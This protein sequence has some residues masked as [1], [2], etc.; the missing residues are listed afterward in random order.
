TGFSGIGNSSQR[1]QF[2]IRQ[3]QFNNSISWIHGRHALKFGGEGRRGSNVD[4]VT[5]IS[6]S[7]GFTP[8]ASGLPGNAATGNGL[9][10]MMV[11][12]PTSFSARQTPALDRYMWYLAGFVQDD[13]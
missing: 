4:V 7:F 2:P 6:G 9:A 11:G 5:A 12:F 1:E 8:Q 3:Y 10:S 13:W